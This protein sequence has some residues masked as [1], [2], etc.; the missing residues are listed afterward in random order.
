LALISKPYVFVNGEVADAPSVDADFDVLYNAVNGGLDSSNISPSAGILNT[1]LAT[2][3]TGGTVNG[4]AL[5][6]LPNIPSAAGILPIANVPSSITPPIPD[7]SLAQ[8][9]TA[10]KVSGTAITGLASLPSG[11]GVIPSANLP[12]PTPVYVP[13][14]NADP[15]AIIASANNAQIGS[16]TTTYTLMKDITLF[17]TGTLSFSWNSHSSGSDGIYTKIYR[18]GSPVGTEQYAGAS[19]KVN[20]D[21]V[22]GWSNGD[23]IQLY[24]KTTGGGGPTLSNFLVFGT[25]CTINTN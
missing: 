23:H 19:P 18:N 9:T 3:N 17:G 13:V 8:I 1:Q 4:S 5:T 7:S 10:S 20:I 16:L 12:T 25:Q 6:G 22:S 21:T 14:Y 24:Y 15:S 2:I 11:A